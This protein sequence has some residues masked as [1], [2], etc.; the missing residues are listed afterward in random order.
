M[1]RY[2]LAALIIACFAFPLVGAQG[3]ARAGA[4][5]L[6]A[7][8]LW[9]KQGVSFWQTDRRF[10]STADT[11]LVFPSGECQRDSVSPGDRICFDP[12]TGGR[13]TTFSTTTEFRLGV[14]DWLQV[15]VILPLLWADFDETLTEDSVASNWGI[16]DIR[17]RTQVGWLIDKFAAAGRLEVKLP[18]GDFDPLVFSAPLTEG[19]LDVALM[20]S[21]GMSL[22]PYGYVNLQLGY[23][24]RFENGQNKRKPGDEFLF[25]AEGGLD[26]PWGLL[27][28]LAFDGLVGSPGENSQFSG[29]PIA[30]PRRRLY[31]VWA[32]L[33]WA[34]TGQLLLEG[35]VRVLLAGEDFPTGVQYWLSAAYEFSLW[36][37]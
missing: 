34:A 7:G 27:A 35:D 17:L 20:S 37:A 11:T 1:G 36:E 8:R 33:V 18:T 12:T 30:L 15:E 16:G 13:L 6:K 25:V 29:A 28:K 21:F 4:W 24:F 14:L 22:Y 32:G 9:V 3:T 31:T 23:R 19:Q 5:N 26:L 10:A 2:P